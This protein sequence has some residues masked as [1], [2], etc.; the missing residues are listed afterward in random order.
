MC[1]SNRHLL[2]YESKPLTRRA[3]AIAFLESREGFGWIVIVTFAAVLAVIAGFGF[4]EVSLDAYVKNKTDEKGTA[5]ELVDAFVSNYS[6]LR[7]D[8]GSESAPGPATFRAHSIELFNRP[9]A[10]GK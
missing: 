6:N 10:P 9:R 8:F 7:R 4:Y 1:V 5:L 2:P 3:A